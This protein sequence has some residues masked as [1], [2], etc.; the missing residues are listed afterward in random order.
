[1]SGNYIKKLISD[2][3]KSLM[4]TPFKKDNEFKGTKGSKYRLSR[5][6]YPRIIA[7][8]FGHG[9]DKIILEINSFANPD[10]TE[11]KVVQSYIGE[12]LLSQNDKVS[13]ERFGLESITVKVLSVKRTFVEKLM[14][15]SRLS[16][17]D[18]VDRTYL[19]EK[20]RHFYDIQK[21]MESDHLSDF[22]DSDDFKN[23][24]KKVLE[25]DMSNNEFKDH[26]PEGKL[27]DIKL[28][29]NLDEILSDLK[30]T[31]NGTLQSLIINAKKDDFNNLILKFN[32]IKKYIPDIDLS[33]IS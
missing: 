32:E 6:H 7:G 8:D 15:L 14:S 11:L 33:N 27:K 3:E 2:V 24:I 26:W 5:H 22:L 21:I 31:Y 4:N 29:T 18:D 30:V 16:C 12:Y 19:K 1:M 10:P 25:D 9:L 28:F 13:V 23:T 20:I 17:I